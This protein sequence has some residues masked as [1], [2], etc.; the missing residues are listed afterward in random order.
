MAVCE[1]VQLP[2]GIIEGPQNNLRR[3]T[4]YGG[5]W[6]EDESETAQV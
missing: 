1:A 6:L 5:T 3:S 2:A 4:A